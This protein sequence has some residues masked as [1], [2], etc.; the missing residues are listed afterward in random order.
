M[1]TLKKSLLV[2]KVWLLVVVLSVSLV[3]GSA[4]F[5]ASL[6]SPALKA[7]TNTI[8][9]KVVVMGTNTDAD[10]NKYAAIKLVCGKCGF[11]MG[12]RNVN[13]PAAFHDE[14]TCNKCKYYNIFDAQLQ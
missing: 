3:M 14:F 6:D 10:G 12:E 5:A 8:Q 4:G 1:V 13:L 11:N 2:R 9:G 7:Q